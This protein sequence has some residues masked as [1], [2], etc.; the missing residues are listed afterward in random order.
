M[1][2]DAAPFFCARA[3]LKNCL[4]LPQ[5]EQR[6]RSPP[7]HQG[8]AQNGARVFRSYSRF[9]GDS[10]V[11]L[12]TDLR[13]L[14]FTPHL[15][16]RVAVAGWLCFTGLL[17]AAAQ[18]HSTRNELPDTTDDHVTGQGWWP[19]KSPASAKGYVGSDSCAECHSTIDSTQSE[20]E[21]A[22]AAF[23]LAG[24]AAGQPAPGDFKSGSYTYRFISNKA[25]PGYSLEVS[26]NGQSSSYPIS[27]T[28]G[29]GVHGQTYLLDGN[30]GMY[31]SQASSFTFTHRVGL[32]PGH[33]PLEE[34][35]VENALGTPLKAGD[36]VRCFACHTT[37]SSANSRLN[38]ADAVPGVHCEACHGPGLD[39][40]KAAMASQKVQAREAIFNPASLTPTSSID[41]CGACHRTTMDVILHEPEPGAFTIR[42]QPYRLEESRCWQTTKDAR[43]ACTECHNPH[44]PMVRDAHFYD[45]KCLSC[46]SLRKDAKHV[47]SSGAWTATP[48]ICPKATA[49]CASCHMPKSNVPEMN[50]PF[51]DHLIRIV[52]PGAPVPN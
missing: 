27:W 15:G 8:I 37:A 50:S 26:S 48:K 16:I 36:A 40:V 13:R 43:L 47:F 39:H 49:N 29:L 22:K 1:A 2:I 35:P 33:K 38:A 12:D 5:P 4:T 28:M 19:T 30:G 14:N 11:N 31:E 34:G 21:M 6:G 46:H 7:I 52:R 41:F 32:S 24:G 18:Q 45:Q 9:G 42:F 25:L 20:S 44:A 3:G 10:S 51:V 17:V 23:R